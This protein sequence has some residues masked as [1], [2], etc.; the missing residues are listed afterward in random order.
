MK[1]YGFSGIMMEICCKLSSS[2]GDGLDKG[3][4]RLKKLLFSRA[5]I[6]SILVAG[7]ILILLLFI[8][9]LSRYFAAMYGVFMLLSAVVTLVVVN[10]EV[11]PSF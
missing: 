2:E 5:L 9:R 8:L 7:Q 4:R 1:N 6:V 10:K 3:I 11:N